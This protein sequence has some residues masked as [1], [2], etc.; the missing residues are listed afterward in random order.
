[1]L[2]Y[3]NVSIGLN[4][5]FPPGVSPLLPHVDTALM[6]RGGDAFISK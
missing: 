3:L 6:M 1:V 4:G 2:T 5:L